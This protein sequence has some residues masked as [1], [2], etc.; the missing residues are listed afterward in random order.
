MPTVQHKVIPEAELHESKGVSTA[1]NNTFYIAN[2]AGSGV[3]KAKLVPYLVTLSPAAVAANTTAE[4]LFTVT[5]I[6][7]GDI[8]IS[9]SKPAAQAGLGIVGERVSAANQVGVTFSNN[10]AA[11]ITPTASEIYSFVAYKL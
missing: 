3:W 6:V 2:G 9:S 7:V 4:Q 5:G 1:V 11:A 10:T 8:L